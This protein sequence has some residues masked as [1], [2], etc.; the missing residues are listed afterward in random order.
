MDGSRVDALDVIQDNRRIYQEPEYARPDKVP[1]GHGDEEIERPAIFISRPCRFYHTHVPRHFKAEQRERHHFQSGE[2]AAEGH[3][4]GRRSRPIHM[5]KRA[6][7]AAP[8][9][10][11]ND[12]V[13]SRMRQLFAHRAYSRQQEGK[14]HR[15]EYLE[16]SLNPE[17]HHPPA[18][19]LGVRKMASLAV[20]ES[21]HVK[22][23]YRYRTVEK[24]MRKTAFVFLILQ[25]GK[26]RPEDQDKPYQHSRDEKQLP[27]P[28]ELDIFIP[29]VP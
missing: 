12:K 20:H 17:M 13:H 28:A 10:Q 9:V 1:E 18:P 24:K 22:Q 15:R 8:Q 2:N 4:G 19:V 29:L 25:G 26:N 16:E 23:R 7:D 3:D 6:H 14:H 11:G 21:R 27:H 5:M